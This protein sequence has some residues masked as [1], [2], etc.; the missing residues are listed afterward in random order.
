MIFDKDFE[1]TLVEV[2]RFSLDEVYYERFNE[3]I[4][5]NYL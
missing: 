2:I 3:Y 5:S 1:K 4:L